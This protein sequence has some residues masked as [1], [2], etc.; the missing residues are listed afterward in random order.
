MNLKHYFGLKTLYVC[1]WKVH[2]IKQ[3]LCKS[4]STEASY[5]IESPYKLH[6]LQAGP[7]TKANL[8]S[9]D[10]LK[11]Y[12]KMVVMRRMEQACA[13]LYKQKVVRGF[14][15]LYA[16]QEA[17]AVGIHEVMRKQDSVITS[18]R[19]HGYT[20]LM[21]NDVL[22]VIA[23][24]TGRKTGVSRGKGGSM[25]MYAPKFYG[26]NG[27]VGAQV[28]LGAGVALAHHYKG[29][30]G[31]CFTLYGD[32][33]ANQGQVFE[34]MNMTMLWK[35]PCIFV[36][37]NNKY[38][39]GTCAN[40]SSASTDYYTRGDYIPGIHA[41]GMDVIACR[42]VAR[43]AIDYCTS[44]KGPIVVETET[45]R[46]Y[47]HSMS[48]PG[49]SYRTRDEVKEMREKYD[50]INTFAR[51]IKEA[52][53]ATDEQLKAITKKV[54][55]E[56][57]KAAKQAATDPVVGLEELSADVEK[58]CLFPNQMLRGLHPGSPLKHFNLQG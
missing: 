16:G 38:G 58:L 54:R 55:D 7:P 5:V 42:E 45:Y 21:A 56:V 50:P 46:Y 52:K 33:A 12:E 37:E 13:D 2:R 30:G 9:A 24:L 53:L 32:G 1:A 18:Y 31:V 51:K 48:D 14:C 39:L 22:G 17:V 57:G 40:R 23:E 49:T 27:I 29:D 8:T 19:C 3:M 26:G 25:H 43:F 20:Q 44:G 34:A 28:P 10:A 35:L 47:G 15:H 6:K 11:I 36:C 4:M 41:D